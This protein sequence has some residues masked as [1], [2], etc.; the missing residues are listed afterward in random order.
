M[1]ERVPRLSVQGFAKFRQALAGKV[2]PQMNSGGATSQS[3]NYP[4]AVF[5][6]ALE[7]SGGAA[8]GGGSDCSWTYNVFTLANQTLG[9]AVAPRSARVAG[10]PYDKADDAGLPAGSKWPDGRGVGT[11]CIV[12]GEL[13]LLWANER[14]RTRACAPA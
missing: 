4:N 3:Q 10:V 2:V 1:S 7:Q 5:A 11:A 8:G 13:L 9:T 12:N 14:P 6:V